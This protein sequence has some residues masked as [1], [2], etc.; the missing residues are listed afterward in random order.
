[1]KNVIRV[2]RGTTAYLACGCEFFNATIR[3]WL[4]CPE[5]M[6]SFL[7]G[8]VLQPKAQRVGR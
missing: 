2:R 5:E 1:M 4:P 3:R 6:G 7:L 8:N